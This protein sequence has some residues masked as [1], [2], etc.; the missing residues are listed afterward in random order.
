MR[1][2]RFFEEYVDET[3]SQSL[4][5]VIAVQ[6]FEGPW[7]KEGG[8][9]FPAVCSPSAGGK[10]FEKNSAVIRLMF[11]AEYLGTHC[12]RIT[13]AQ[14]RTIHPKLFEYLDSLA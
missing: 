11:N 3:R 14:A 2:Y 1:G 7:V 4:Q 9:C 13:E 6:T 8:V 12:R 10:T 5:S